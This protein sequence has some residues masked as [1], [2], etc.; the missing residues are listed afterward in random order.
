MSDS[1]K[2]RA[3]AYRDSIKRHLGAV[4]NRIEAGDAE[5]ATATDALERIERMANALPTDAALHDGEAAGGTV[6]GASA[7]GEACALIEQIAEL[8][9]SDDFDHDLLRRVRAVAAGL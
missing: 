2:R 4:R 9:D 7:S 6:V 3:I 1:S 5:G 8:D